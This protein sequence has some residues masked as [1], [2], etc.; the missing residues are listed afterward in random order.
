MIK[1]QKGKV[2]AKG[3]A[4]DIAGEVIDVLRSKAIQKALMILQAA[5]L[6]KGQDPLLDSQYGEIAYNILRCCEKVEENLQ[7]LKDKG[8]FEE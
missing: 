3:D 4:F 2:V 6:K 5:T 1:S 8:Y 7:V